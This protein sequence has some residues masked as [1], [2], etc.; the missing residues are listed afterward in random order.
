MQEGANK[1]KDVWVGVEQ[2]EGL[3]TIIKATTVLDKSWDI[4]EYQLDTSKNNITQ[5]ILR[6]RL[7]VFVSMS[8]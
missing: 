1:E 4:R 3:Y 2:L 5:S 6:L 7:T 8:L